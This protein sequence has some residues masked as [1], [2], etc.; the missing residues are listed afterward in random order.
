MALFLWF[1]LRG[2]LNPGERGSTTSSRRAEE[3]QSYEV[4]GGGRCD[5]SGAENFFNICLFFR[6]DKTEK[7]IILPADEFNYMFYY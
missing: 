6:V 7:P 1:A 2:D 5:G 4:R 3:R